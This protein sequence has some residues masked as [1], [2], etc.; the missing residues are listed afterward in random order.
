MDGVRF[1]SRI[2]VA[3]IPSCLAAS[4][5]NQPAFA[6]AFPESRAFIKAVLLTSTI[7]YNYVSG[8]AF[9][10]GYALHAKNS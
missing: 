6:L 4:I 2:I 8:N 9:R 3:N 1:M 7:I 10:R 5:C